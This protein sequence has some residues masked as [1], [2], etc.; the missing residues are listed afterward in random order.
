MGPIDVGNEY[1]YVATGAG[2][3]GGLKFPGQTVIDNCRHMQVLVGDFG[4]RKKPKDRQIA[5]KS[6]FFENF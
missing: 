2:T 1:R 5:N 4:H 6:R 3:G